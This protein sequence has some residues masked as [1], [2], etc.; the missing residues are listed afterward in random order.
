MGIKKVREA[1]DWG[2]ILIYTHDTRLVCIASASLETMAAASAGPAQ[3]RQTMG[4]ITA[5]VP[6]SS[7]APE[8]PV[9]PTWLLPPHAGLWREAE[10]R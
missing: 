1:Q 6:L 9:P 3:L 10:H 2:A 7:S 8:S 4:P 5:L